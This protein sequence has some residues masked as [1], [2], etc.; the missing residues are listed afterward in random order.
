MI[1]FA[2][3]YQLCQLNSLFRATQLICVNFQGLLQ[4]SESQ[5]FSC[6]KTSKGGNCAKVAQFPSSDSI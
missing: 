5:A 3:A 4:T 2:T 1:V 6:A